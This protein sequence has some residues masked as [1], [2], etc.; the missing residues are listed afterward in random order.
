MD[1]GPAFAL[2]P[3][4][5]LS[6]L[7]PHN[8]PVYLFWPPSLQWESKLHEGRDHFSWLTVCCWYLIQCLAHDEDSRNH[9]WIWEWISTL[10]RQVKAGEMREGAQDLG[11]R[12]VSGGRR[13]IL[14]HCLLQVRVKNFTCW[15]QEDSYE[16]LWLGEIRILEILL[17]NCQ[18][19]RIPHEVL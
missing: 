4:H 18:A 6:H 3:G 17:E 14:K 9:G 8:N 16:W 5:V 1:W 12:L 10:E 13:S 11:A 7:I 15:L 19:S 2:R